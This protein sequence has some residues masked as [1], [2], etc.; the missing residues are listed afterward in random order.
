MSDNKLD[1]NIK[2][3]QSILISM[4]VV[5]AAF[6][7]IIVL[8]LTQTHSP[9]IVPPQKINLVLLNVPTNTVTLNFINNSI[10][11]N[12]NATIEVQTQGNLTFFANG[13]SIPVAGSY[14]YLIYG[15]Q[16][17]IIYVKAG[18][19]IEF[20]E[21]NVNKYGLNDFA[22]TSDITPYANNINLTKT[23]PPEY[24]S[25]E[26]PPPDYSNPN[27][28]VYHYSYLMFNATN[29]GT[30]YYFSTVYPDLFY[31][32]EGMIVVES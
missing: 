19:Y 2:A 1:K 18:S 8:L 5:V 16:D 28:P 27:A 12:G 21:V 7:V 24:L 4:L 14:H 23:N 25:P 31:G 9:A 3:T 26:L 17:P 32:M 20:V 10:V 15:M 22:I 13:K 30:Y 6:A 29:L 11:V